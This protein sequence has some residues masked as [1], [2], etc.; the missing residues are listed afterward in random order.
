MTLLFV[1]LLISVVQAKTSISYNFN[2]KAPIGF[3]ISKFKEDGIGFYTNINFNDGIVI[4]DVSY[5]MVGYQIN[6]KTKTRHILTTFG[7]NYL[8]NNTVLYV[9]IGVHSAFSQYQYKNMSEFTSKWKEGLGYN[10]YGPNFNTGMQI[11]GG[12][13]MLITLG[14][15][16]NP[17]SFSG[18]IG[19]TF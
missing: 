3:S 12:K 8:Y 2:I 17:L 11:I 19:R 5:E 18:G 9:G 6:Q 10:K 16:S 14:I 15:D 7:T 4:K 13:N 1:L